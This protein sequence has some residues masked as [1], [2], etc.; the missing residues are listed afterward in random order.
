MR[1]CIMNGKIKMY[2]EEKGFGFILGDDENDYFFHIS[3]VKS[4]DDICRGLSVEFTAVEGQKGPVATKIR[5]LDKK[6]K[7]SKFV[8]FGDIRIK[9][10]NIKNY[11]IASENQYGVYVY[12]DSSTSSF[13]GVHVPKYNKS[14]EIIWID[15]DEWFFYSSKERFNSWDSDIVKNT[16]GEYLSVHMFDEDAKELKWFYGC[17]CK[18]NLGHVFEMPYS[19][20]PRENLVCKTKE[21]LYVTTYQ[22]DNYR[23]FD[24]S[25]PF[26]IH[27]KGKELDEIFAE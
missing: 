27:E 11:G 8:T 26:D 12:K 21:Y 7:A 4:A 10:S 18:N 16:N 15:K 2:N 24:D 14:N 20:N 17:V 9:A 19:N 5:I 23:F 3:E 13:L 25:A 6:S 22:R 1:G